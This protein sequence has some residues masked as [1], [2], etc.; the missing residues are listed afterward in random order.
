M[1]NIWIDTNIDLAVA[2]GG[3]V[4]ASLM[5]NFSQGTT[6]LQQMT[7]LRSVIGIDFAPVVMDSGEGSTEV[8]AGIGIA[9]AEAFAAETL[10]DPATATDYPTRGWVWKGRYRV[11]ATAADRAVLFTRRVDLDMRSQRKL[12]NGIGYLIIDNNAHEGSTVAIQAFGL[13][14]QLW[15]VR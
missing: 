1:P 14:R 11:W 9:T 12:D 3:Q 4:V 10:P 13:I 5:T 7:L 2:S 6:R 15:L 8:S